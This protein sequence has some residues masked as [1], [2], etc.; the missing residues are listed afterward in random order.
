MFDIG[1]SHMLVIAVV[2]IIVLGPE[3]LPGFAQQAA[4][5][6]R[7]V[8]AMLS[9]AQAQLRDEL[10]EDFAG[11]D[12]RNLDPRTAIKR[13]LQDDPTADQ[14]DH[15]DADQDELDDLDDVA[16]PGLLHD[17]YNPPTR[18]PGALR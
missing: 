9:E 2:G 15:D 6:I 17:P 7:G 12:P 14:D 11:L 1:I 10:G 18:V 8:K 13:A 16:G 5:A 4:G 3:K